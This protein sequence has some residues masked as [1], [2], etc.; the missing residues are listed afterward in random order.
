MVAVGLSLMAAGASLIPYLLAGRL[1]GDGRVFA[2]FL[3]NPTDGFSYLAKMRQGAAGSWMFHLPYAREPGDGA[4][5]FTHYLFLGHLA[6]WLGLPLLHL[7]HAARLAGSVA[8]HLA[9]FWLFSRV[10]TE[11]KARWLAYGWT[12]VGSGLGW[13][14]L[15]LGRIAAD[16]WVP[17]LI[18]SL[19]ALVSAHFPLAAAAYVAALVSLLPGGSMGL[20]SALAAVCGLLLSVLQPFSVVALL[21]VAGAWLLWEAIRAFRG[22]HQGPAFRPGTSLAPLTAFSV[23]ALPQMAYDLWAFRAVPAMRLWS[24]Q[25]QTPSP[26]VIDYVFGLGL[27]GL[28]ALAGAVSGRVRASPEGRLL[29]AWAVVQGGLLYAPVGVQRRLAL[30]WSFAL[31]SL[32]ALALF[33]WVR[34]GRARAIGFALVIALSLPTNLL[35]VSAALRA[36]ADGDPALVLTE[37][38]VAGYRWLAENARDWPLVLAAPET[39]TRLPAYAPVRVLYGHPFETPS[40]AEQRSLVEALFRSDQDPAEGLRALRD[41]KVELIF[42]GPREQELGRPAWL[43][44]LEPVHSGEGVSIYEVPDR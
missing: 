27:V 5:L 38:E 29:F 28:M 10:L 41:L 33:L 26:P 7:F 17:E 22:G 34:S 19:S 3:L 42:Y 16:L 30:G 24:A 21:A 2:G 37:G 15:P 44:V 35:V 39:G 31:A 9:A 40:A 36:V 18:P 11:P 23:A 43:G 8:M 4:F 25:N 14:A 32:A 1:A 6:R 12:L 13:M 20:R